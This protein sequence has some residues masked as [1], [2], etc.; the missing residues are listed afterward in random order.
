MTNLKGKKL[1]ILCGYSIHVKVV[2]AAKEMGVYTIVTDNLAIED[3]PA[4]AIADEALFIN[5]FDTDAI[6]KYC[7]EN[8][9]DGVLNFHNDPSQQQHR[10]ICEALG[11]PCY[12]NE[13]QVNYLTNKD[14][15]KECCAKFG[16]DTIPQYS[17]ED[18]KQGKV[19]YPL[20]VKPTDSRGS[21]GSTVCYNLDDVDKAIIVAKS[22][23]S[24]GNILIEKYMGNKN[25]FC[26]TYVVVNGEV[27]LTRASDRRLGRIEDKMER[28]SM[29]AMAPSKYASWYYENVSERVAN[30]LKGIGLKNSPA[31][32]QGFV[33]GDTVRFYDPG[34]R[35][36]GI[37]YER[38]YN[39]VHGVN[40]MKL[41][42]EYALT[43]KISTDVVI[44]KDGFL[45]KG[46]VTPNLFISIKPGKITSIKGMDEIKKH[47]AVVSTVEKYAVGDVVPASYNVNQRYCEIDLICENVD[48]LCSIIDWVYDTLIILDENGENMVFS[49]IDTKAFKKEYN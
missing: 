9:V 36:P 31:F 15:F 33:D 8:N 37:E 30:M 10:I 22:E 4:K 24:S 49:K 3:S 42:I 35:F 46:K 2:E 32:M 14:L 48:E 39:K 44:P 11:L 17:Y 16:V 23:S 5:I 29:M 38:M 12:G 13:E 26:A 34:I 21:R 18:V 43:G 47:K 25:D 7:K 27:Y 6:I 19:E 28:V 41:F 20:L 1:L 45:N 40:F